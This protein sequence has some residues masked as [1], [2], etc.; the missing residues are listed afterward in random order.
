MGHW[1][2]ILRAAVGDGR[3]LQL[4]WT[5]WPYRLNLLYLAHIIWTGHLQLF[6]AR[7]PFVSCNHN[8]ASSAGSAGILVGDWMAAVEQRQCTRA[9]KRTAVAGLG[10]D[11]A[12][13]VWSE[14]ALFD[15]K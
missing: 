6:H 11:V 3:I 12:P 8:A 1:G 14:Q 13:Y 15:A 7:Y 9:S 10:E 4:R 2:A 5:V